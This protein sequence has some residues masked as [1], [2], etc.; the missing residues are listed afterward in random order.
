MPLPQTCHEI[1][2]AVNQAFTMG[3]MT[4]DLF[5][6]IAIINSLEDFPHTHSSILC[7]LHKS[8]KEKKYASKNI[9]HYLESEETLHPASQL[10]LTSDI[11]LT[12]CTRSFN[13]PTCSNC[14]HQGH[15]NQYCISP[16]GGMTGKTIQEFKDKHQRDRNN[17]QEIMLQYLPTVM[18]K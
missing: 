18:E 5:C 14:K 2:N 6:C 16:G 17:A 3:T 8:T 7:D 13:V 12:T 11:V 4:A 15:S 10:P 1:C 9:H